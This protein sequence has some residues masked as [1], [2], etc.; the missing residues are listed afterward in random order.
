MKGLIDMKSIHNARKFPKIL[1]SVLRRAKNSRTID[2][3]VTIYVQDQGFSIVAFHALT[4]QQYGNTEM[5][6]ALTSYTNYK[7]VQQ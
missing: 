7:K 4:V 5:L 3:L 6:L 1:L 2:A